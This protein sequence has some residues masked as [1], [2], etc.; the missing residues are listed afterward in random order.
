MSKNLMRFYPHFARNVLLVLD[1]V[2][3]LLFES[4]CAEKNNLDCIIKRL[5]VWK[6][7]IFAMQNRLDTFSAGGYCNFAYNTYLL[8]W[9]KCF[10]RNGHTTDIF[11]TFATYAKEKYQE[12]LPCFQQIQKTYMEHFPI[13]YLVWIWEKETYANLRW[14]IF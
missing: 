7:K 14:S 8:P 11:V 1:S 9:K 5:A 12:H 10:E 2:R 13:S 4:V 6:I 3:N